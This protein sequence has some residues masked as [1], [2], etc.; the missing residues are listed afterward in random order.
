MTK[1][2]APTQ[3]RLMPALI[4]T[5]GVVLALKAAAAAEAANEAAPAPPAA[6]ATE[7]ATGAA[8]PPAAPAAPAAAAPAAQCPAPSFA[9]QA[10]LSQSEVRVL[11]TL[12]ERRK[13]IDARAA[14]IEKKA[15][16]LSAAETRVEERIAELKKL[17]ASLQ[18]MLGQ[19]DEAQEQRIAGLVAVYQKMR[20]K[21][22][23]AVFN[24]LDDEVLLNVASR[25]KQ[26]NLADILGQMSPERARKLTKMLAESKRPLG[27]APAAPSAPRA[28]PPRTSN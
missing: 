25:M 4:A 20:A 9:D 8:A 19:L 3:V 18:G 22:A 11:Q 14:E 13:A 5:L 17:E 24:G 23:A 21:D 12:G 26:A 6:A 15:D 1:P 2:S 7:T 16:L 27:P 10:G 28:A